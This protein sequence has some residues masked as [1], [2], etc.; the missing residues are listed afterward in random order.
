MQKLALFQIARS[1]LSWRSSSPLKS[2]HSGKEER[3]ISGVST[4]S[5]FCAFSLSLSSSCSPLLLLLFRVKQPPL[6]RGPVAQYR[7]RRQGEEVARYLRGD[8]EQ[9]GD[10]GSCCLSFG[11][12]KSLFFVCFSKS[13]SS[14]LASL[15]S[16]SQKPKKK[17]APVRAIAETLHTANRTGLLPRGAGPEESAASRIAEVALEDEE[18]EIDEEGELAGLPP[19]LALPLLLLLPPPP[20]TLRSPESEPEADSS[21]S[22][23]ESA[24]ASYRFWKKVAEDLALAVARSKSLALALSASSA[25]REA[26]SSSA[27]SS[28]MRLM[29]SCVFVVVVVGCVCVLKKGK[30]DEGERGRELEREGRK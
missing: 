12:K 2:K 4:I 27:S 22:E 24:G 30:G 17:N 10:R 9:I 6:H 8:A 23:S 26:A 13:S 3:K 5:F 15:S 25:A 1:A 19:P 29:S 7:S 20:P 21:E 16:K 14:L 11:E 28:A 18:E